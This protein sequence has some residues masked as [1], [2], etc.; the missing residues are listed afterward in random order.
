[1][2]DIWIDVDTAL[3]EAPVNLM[4]IV[5]AAG[6]TIDDG[7]TYDEAGMDLN[8]NFITTAGAYSQTNVVPTTGGTHDWASLGNGM[9]SLEIPASGGTINNDTEGFGW[10]SGFATAVLPWR[11]PVVGFRAVAINNS[12]ID[13]PT[14][15]VNVTAMAADVIT[16]ASVDEDA[17]FIIQALSITNALDAGSVLVDGA[18]TLT[19]NVELSANLAIVGTQT[20]TGVVTHTAGLA[21][22]I[23]GNIT[24]NLSGSVGSLTGH[25]NQTADHTAGIGDIPTVAEFEARSI[26]SA[27]YT[28]V[29]DLGT[30][31]SGDSYAIVNGA[32]GLVSI[33][34]DVDLILAGTADMQ[35]RVVAIEIDTGITLDALIKDVPTVAEFEARTIVSADYVVVGD[36]LAR[37]TLVDT[38][39]TNT[40]LNTA[41]AEPG[42]GAPAVNATPLSKLAYIYKAWRNKKDNDG[43]TRN[44]YADDASTVDQKSGVGEAAGT[45][46]TDE[47][48]SGP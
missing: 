36:T 47:W 20:N 32:H 19:G 34:D 16:P 44:L 31:Q 4:P 39:T 9:Y 46:T 17:N 3:S 1:M 26:V 11:G 15:D 18:T 35:P 12:L 5:V 6:T 43:T 30:V 37:V 27:D 29:G 38:V 13:G 33:Q 2:P 22:A 21:S 8:W 28:V 23:T 41:Q 48:E 14:V 10:F 24:G 42:Q 7:V 40:D 25:T 45:V